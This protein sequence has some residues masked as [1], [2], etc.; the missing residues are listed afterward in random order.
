[1]PVMGLQQLE[2]TGALVIGAYQK[3]T[4]LMQL[5]LCAKKM[6][7]ELNDDITRVF[8]VTLC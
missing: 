2:D 5:P 8:S 4:H 3:H 1:M 7:V 6:E